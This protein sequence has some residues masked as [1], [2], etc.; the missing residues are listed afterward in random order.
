MRREST[1]LSHYEGV[2]TTD[3]VISELR[4][5]YFSKGISVSPSRL[6]DYVECG[7]R[8]YVRRLLGVV[9]PESSDEGV[10]SREVGRIVHRILYRFFLKTIEIRDKERSLSLE[11]AKGLMLRDRVRGT[12][13][14]GRTLPADPRFDLAKTS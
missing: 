13:G 7:F 1:R 5:T 9:A 8:Y 11:D 2:F 10:P 6:E 12:E 14:V 4:E 3:R